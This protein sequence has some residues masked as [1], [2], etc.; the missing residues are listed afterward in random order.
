MKCSE[1]QDDFASRRA[2]LRSLSDEQLHAY[3]WELVGRIVDPLVEEA[4]THTTPS[5]ERSV[6]L[7][8]GFSSVEAKALVE[9]MRQRALLGHGAGRLVLELAKAK[10]VDVRKVGQGLLA[11]QYWEEL[12]L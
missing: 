3:F 4:R 11:G 9:Q 1:R 10:G 7:R 12:P 5:I 6:L 2:H 8:M